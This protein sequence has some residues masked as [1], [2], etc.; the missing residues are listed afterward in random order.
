MG[1]K[2]LYEVEGMGS[3]KWPGQPITRGGVSQELL[4]D[5]SLETSE[6][7]KPGE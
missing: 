7:A 6:W 5:G 4:G 1:L 3:G 2:R